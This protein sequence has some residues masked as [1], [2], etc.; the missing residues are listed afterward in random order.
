[1]IQPLFSCI[2]AIVVTAGDSPVRS[3]AVKIL[4][5]E[6]CYAPEQE[7]FDFWANSMDLGVSGLEL[8]DNFLV[9]DE[10]ASRFTN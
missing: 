8:I 1:M 10:Y 7:G 5:I 3:G 6:M 9:S 4:Q 2:F